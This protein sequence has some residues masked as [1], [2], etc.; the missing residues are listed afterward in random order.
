MS[1]TTELCRFATADG[2][3][4]HG[5]LFGPADAAPAAD[6]AVVAIHGVAMNFYS[7]PQL[8]VGQMLAERG[9]HALVANNRGHDWV[10]RA[11]DLTAFGGA[12]YERIEDCLLD[13]DGTLRWLA[14]RGYRRYVLFGHSLGGIKALYYQGNRQRSDVVG[15]VSCSTP[16][17]YYRAR[18]EEQ[19]DFEERM[20]GAEAQVAAGRG[21]EFLW[22][23]TTG[24]PG[25][26]TAQTYV[27]KYGRHEHNDVRPYAARLGCPLLA[28]AGSAEFHFFPD[29]A[30][31]LAALAAPR[32]TCEIVEGANHFYS[33]RLPLLADVVA[34]WLARL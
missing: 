11:G 3:T 14:E 29:L 33:G 4:L 16:R 15:L 24:A 2:Q 9:Y 30:R 12:S 1:I 18:A 20:A 25:L 17:Q 10:S 26:F 13:L 8:V 5:L 6:L 32:G 23:P 21:D 27:N 31:E 22:A 28:T 7:G 34:V 19:P